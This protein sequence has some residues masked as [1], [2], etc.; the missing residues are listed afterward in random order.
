[1][2]ITDNLEKSIRCNFPGA[3]NAAVRNLIRQQIIDGG[4]PVL[5]KSK[6]A[7][8]FLGVAGIDAVQKVFEE[9]T[10]PG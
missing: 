3:R 10:M 6:I 2:T 8:S 4:D 1:M 5:L 9:E 7:F